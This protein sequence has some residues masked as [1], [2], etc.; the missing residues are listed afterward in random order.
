VVR[1]HGAPPAPFQEVKGKALKNLLAQ[2]QKPHAELKAGER[3]L[4]KKAAG[5][6]EKM[7]A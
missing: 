3:A 1:F 7:I 5:Q 2:L 4:L 6:I